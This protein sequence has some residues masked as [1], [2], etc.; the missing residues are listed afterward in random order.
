MAVL[1]KIRRKH[2]RIEAGA[3]IAA[4]HDSL[5][6]TEPPIRRALS[7]ERAQMKLCPYCGQAVAHASV[8]ADH[9]YPIALGGLSTIENMVVRQ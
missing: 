2:R 6:G 9:I 8:V 3:K 5:R 1:Q 4:F 7:A